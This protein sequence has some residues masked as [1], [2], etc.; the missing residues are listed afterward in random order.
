MAH[1][2]TDT[3]GTN[4]HIAVTFADLRAIRDQFGVNFLDLN[5]WHVWAE[6]PLAPEK[7]VGILYFL[8]AEQIERAGLSP[9]QFGERLGGDTLDDALEALQ[10]AV[11]DF[12]PKRL[13]EPM[14]AALKKHAEAQAMAMQTA[15]LQIQSAD[16]DKILAEMQ[17]PG[18]LSVELP[19]SQESTRAP[20]RPANFSP[21]P[22]PA[23]NTT[24]TAPRR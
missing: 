1:T 17:T 5:A 20:G 18:P 11:A 19:P 15:T 12:F 21:W 4:W 3:D 7:L 24:G 13:R 22:E 8:L 6:L 23:A 10:L 9:E 14:K 16:V 2:F